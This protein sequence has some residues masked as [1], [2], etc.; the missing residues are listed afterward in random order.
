VGHARVECICWGVD[1]WMGWNGTAEGLL[2]PLQQR[3]V[4]ALAFGPFQYHEGGTTVT[5]GAAAKEATRDGAAAAVVVVFV[6]LQRENISRPAETAPVLS[7]TPTPV[8]STRLRRHRSR[9]P[10]PI[11]FSAAP[12]RASQ[13]PSHSLN[14]PTSGW[15][16]R[17]DEPQRP[18]GG[19]SI[20]KHL[21]PFVSLADRGRAAASRSPSVGQ[22]PSVFHKGGGWAGTEGQKA[23]S[24]CES[25]GSTC[26]S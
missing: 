1:G 19:N 9:H 8:G 12:D 25:S 20:Q 16:R 23:G 11:P 10:A 18:S 4:E 2:L 15:M 3:R 17:L 14:L 13:P 21:P 5:N 7:I 22:G 6:V 24:M 26:A